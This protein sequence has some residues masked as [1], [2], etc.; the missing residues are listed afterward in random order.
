MWDSYGEIMKKMIFIIGLIIPLS[1]S[2]ESMFCTLDQFYSGNDTVLNRSIG[3]PL[4]LNKIPHN[5]PES[6]NFVLDFENKIYKTKN[7]KKRVFNIYSIGD[8]IVGTVID[9]SEDG[10][11]QLHFNKRT[12]KLFRTSNG[13]FYHDYVKKFVTSMEVTTYGCI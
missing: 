6:E 9:G 11:Y 1:V 13:G 12:K 4:P 10:F 8:E 5:S 7:M 2:G 3:E